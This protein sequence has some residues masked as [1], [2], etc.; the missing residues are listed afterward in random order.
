MRIKGGRGVDCVPLHP[1]VLIEIK[2]LTIASMKAST[3]ATLLFLAAAAAPS[4]GLLVKRDQSIGGPSGGQ[5]QTGGPG[6]SSH[7][8]NPVWTNPPPQRTF[9]EGVL[10]DH[11]LKL[12]ASYQSNTTQNVL[13]YSFSEVIAPNVR[14]SYKTK[15][16]D[17]VA[18]FTYRIGFLA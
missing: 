1:K 10:S 13:E 3:V 14:L 6:P 2:T 17:A 4:E 11:G 7:N 8:Q 15:S 16:N 5:N 12:E 9:V 18:A